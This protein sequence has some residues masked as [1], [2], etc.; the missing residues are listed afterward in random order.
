MSPLGRSL[1]LPKWVMSFMDGPDV[2]YY[3]FGFILL[4]CTKWAKN[5]KILAWQSNQFLITFFPSRCLMWFFHQ[6]KCG[7]FLNCTT[8]SGYALIL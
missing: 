5:G 7:S 4:E 2:C 6:K 3:I 8:F 1:H